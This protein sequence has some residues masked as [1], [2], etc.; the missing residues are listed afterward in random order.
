MTEYGAPPDGWWESA[1]RISKHCAA[2]Y[3]GDHVIP[4]R[5]RCEHA[6]DGIVEHVA[7]HGWPADDIDPVFRA[8]RRA[9]D[10]AT[11][12]ARKH[13]FRR[14]FWL[15]PSGTYDTLAE[16][17]TD[18]IAV[19]QVIW[20]F[21]PGQWEAVWAVAEADKRGGKWR[22]GAAL[23]GA[24]P[25]TFST[26]LA[27]ARARARAAWIAPGETPPGHYGYARDAPGDYRNWRGQRR[28]HQ[29][30]KAAGT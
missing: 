10:H 22:D 4:Y 5:D 9:L 17:V 27:H 21:T 3:R 23:V 16:S 19:W 11:W 8:A 25:G 6:L 30:R 26:Q 14:E 18:R 24:H 20:S 7:S 12:E 28:R 15:E 29:R 13:I 1:Q 2:T